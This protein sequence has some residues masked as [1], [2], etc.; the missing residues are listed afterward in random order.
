MY[1]KNV[2]QRKSGLLT[3]LDYRSMFSVH[4]NR[5][6]LSTRI[7]IKSEC[8]NDKS[9]GC[10]NSIFRS[11][12][13]QAP[14]H[15]LLYSGIHWYWERRLN[16]D[17]PVSCTVNVYYTAKISDIQ[18]CKGT[19]RKEGLIEWEKKR[20]NPRQWFWPCTSIVIIIGYLWHWQRER[21]RESAT[22]TGHQSLE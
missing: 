10:Q 5:G 15:N 7:L 11:F 8:S 3:N 19:N 9:P 2:A 18:Y 13:C 17:I 6:L 21:E 16:S 1:A 22:W 20:I 14:L 4:Q 12:H